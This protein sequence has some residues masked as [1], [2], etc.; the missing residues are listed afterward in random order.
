VALV[1]KLLPEEGFGFLATP[2]GREIYFHQRSVLH[3]GFRRLKVG[4]EVTFVEEQGERGAQAS[5]VRI[6][7]QGAVRPSARAAAAG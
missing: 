1:S 3:G 7:R 4:S 2:D 6:R 5:T